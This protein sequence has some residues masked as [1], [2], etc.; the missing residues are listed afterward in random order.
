MFIH[1]LKFHHIIHDMHQKVP[2]W[3]R[4]KMVK[5]WYMASDIRL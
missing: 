1:C 4:R 3:H 5:K 2:T